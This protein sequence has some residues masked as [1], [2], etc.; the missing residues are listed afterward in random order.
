MKTKQLALT[1]LNQLDPTL[2]F[3]MWQNAGGEPIGNKLRD[4]A[5][6]LE[7]DIA[8]PVEPVSLS[9][10]TA[11]RFYANGSHLHI[12]GDHHDFDTVSGEPD[13]LLFSG[14][15]DDETMLE[16][17]GI[18]RQ[19]L[20]GKP[21]L[22]VDGDDDE[23][24]KPIDGEAINATPQEPAASFKGPEKWAPEEVEMGN[25]G[26]RWVNESG[27]QGRPTECDIRQYL[28]RTPTAKGCNCH[29]CKQLYTQEPATRTPYGWQVQGLRDTF[30][31]EH[32]ETDAKAEAKRVGGTAYA[33]QIFTTPQEPAPDSP[34]RQLERHN[35]YSAGFDEATK[36]AAIPEG[37]MLV[38]VEP[39]QEMR[40]AG[41][42]AH[43][44]AENKIDEPGAY[45]PGGFARRA[46]RASHVYKAMLA[47]APGA[48]S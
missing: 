35:D 46:V 41:Q 32:A 8:K 48:Q 9:I 10:I 15:D 27:V 22:W 40:K 1:L 14:K 33:F 26:I 39:T 47:A 7:A 24:P 29:E 6:A 13:N 37:W 18:A 45:A 21:I 25:I 3:S 20:R 2:K 12:D 43:Y 28:E 31:G 30:F 23:T 38:P 4:L 17:G 5:A 34:E 19:A 16:D 36:R 44:E 11:L 42:H